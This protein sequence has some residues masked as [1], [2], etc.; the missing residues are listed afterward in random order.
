MLKRFWQKNKTNFAL[1]Q[2][3]ST[4]FGGYFIIDYT[5]SFLTINCSSRV[6][7]KHVTWKSIDSW[8]G[9]VF[10]SKYSAFQTCS[11]ACLFVNGWVH[12]EPSKFEQVLDSI[13]R[14]LNFSSNWLIFTGAVRPPNVW[15]REQNLKIMEVGNK[16]GLL[17]TPNPEY[18]DLKLSESKMLH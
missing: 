2:A 5:S 12:Q 6:P 11:K 18:S 10:I 9:L 15:P 14:N 16:D 3:C 13:I 17:G 4:V 8:L 7:T 1:L